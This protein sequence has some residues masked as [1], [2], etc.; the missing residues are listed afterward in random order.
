MLNKIDFRGDVVAK[1]KR[2]N[3]MIE[4]LTSLDLAKIGLT[5]NVIGDIFGYFS[6]LKGEEEAANLAADTNKMGNTTAV[7]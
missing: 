7:K 3:L 1:G 5:L 4:E 2:N 6:I